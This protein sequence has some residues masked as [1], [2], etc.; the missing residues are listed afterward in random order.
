MGERIPDNVRGVVQALKLEDLAS[1]AVHLL[2]AD[3]VV[4]MHQEIKRR[5]FRNSTNNIVVS[6]RT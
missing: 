2:D 4:S 5:K 3:N 6:Q 1:A